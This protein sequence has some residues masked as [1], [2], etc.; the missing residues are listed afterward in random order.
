[1]IVKYEVQICKRFTV[2]ALILA[3]LSL[4]P[5]LRGQTYI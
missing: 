4:K 1:M 3:Q 2:K 5:Q